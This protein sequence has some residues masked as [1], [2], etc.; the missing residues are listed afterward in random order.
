LRARAS[1]TDPRQFPNRSPRSRP[2]P[3]YRVHV[4]TL[5]ARWSLIDK[6]AKSL[7]RTVRF[8]RRAFQ[9]SL[10]DPV[11]SRTRQLS[12][13]RQQLSSNVV[14][15]RDG[16]RRTR[17]SHFSH[18]AFASP[19][20][21]R[22]CDRKRVPRRDRRSPERRSAGVAARNK[23][24]TRQ[25]G[26]ARGRGRERARRPVNSREYCGARYRAHFRGRSS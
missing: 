24:V 17:R 11:I 16:D 23:A 25:T 8:V 3:N 7:R 10:S 4:R 5:L 20:S 15:S 18:F 12:R 19:D 26:R 21:N 6:H 2:L 14:F 13:E 22:R 9:S 1:S